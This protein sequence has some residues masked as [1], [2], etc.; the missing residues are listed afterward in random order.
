MPFD[1]RFAFV[2]VATFALLSAAAAQQTAPS[3][4]DIG[5]LDV[6][7]LLLPPP[8]DSCV[9]TQAELAELQSLQRART[10][11]MIAHAR[12]DYA[13]TPE[14]FLDGM[15]IRV[16]APALGQAAPLLKCAADVAEGAVDKAKLQ[17]NRTRPYKLPNNGLHPLKK[18]AA[19]DAPSYP[20][21][22]SAFGSVTGLVLAALD[23]DLRDSFLLRIKDFGYSRLVSGVH[24][25]SDVYAGEL[26]GATAAAM[27]LRNED[28]LKRIDLASPD[29]RNAI[30][31][32]K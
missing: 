6:H 22:H 4:P 2:L 19:N 21:G 20:S 23:P 13:R 18:I 7:A 25:R 5:E 27:L 26:V 17:F 16:A 28:F 15:G 9:I 8:C 14:R 24:Y 1:R 30:A 31:A 11:A 12:A 10:P 3:C 29:L 32:A